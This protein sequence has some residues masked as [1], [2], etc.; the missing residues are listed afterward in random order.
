MSEKTFVIEKSVYGGYGLAF[1]SNHAYFIR[2]TLPGEVVSITPYEEKSNI[3]F[4]AVKKLY[5]HSIERQESDCPSFPEC[6]GCAY[7]HTNYANELHLKKLIIED[8]LQR[9]AGLNNYPK[10]KTISDKR[11]HYRSITTIQ[12]QNHLKG[13]HAFKSNRLI[14]FPEKG[15]L[16]LQKELIQKIKAM[17]GVDGK[18]KMATDASGEVYSSNGKSIVSEKCGDY[19]YVHDVNSFFQANRLLR[20]RMVKE[21]LSLLRRYS[22]S[23]IIDAGCGC[24]FFSLPAAS[25]SEFVTGFDTDRGSIESAKNNACINGIKNVRFLNGDFD[26][27]RKI[28]DSIIIADPPRSGLTKMFLTRIKQEKPK[29]IIYVSCNPSTWARDIGMLKGVFTPTD[30][31]FIDMFSGTHHIETIS[32]LKRI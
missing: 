15:C 9:I 6:G 12:T 8:A 32:L 16:L 17:S 5:T 30:L 10:I 1:A 20:E 26:S 31:T 23:Q 28:K 7:L 14:P 25:L 2:N 24:G 3:T 19:S 18:I 22:G 11:Y 4:A 21:V 13:F 29:A 27:I